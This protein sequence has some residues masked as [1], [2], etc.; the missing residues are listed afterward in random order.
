MG[1]KIAL[2]KCLPEEENIVASP[3]TT[4]GLGDDQGY[5]VS[6]IPTMFDGINKLTDYELGGIADVIVYIPKPFTDN[7]WALVL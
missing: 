5:L 7:V 1:G 6:I 2:F 3:A 4:T